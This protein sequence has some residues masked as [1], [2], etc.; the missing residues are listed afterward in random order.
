MGL[1]KMIIGLGWDP[2]EGT[3]STFDLDVSAI[4]IDEKRKMPNKDYFVFYGNL[5]SPDGVYITEKE[6][7]HFGAKWPP[8]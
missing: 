1:S 5:N 4:M 2:N 7:L 6:S 8:P 3:G